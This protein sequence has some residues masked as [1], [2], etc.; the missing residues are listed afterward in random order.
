MGSCIRITHVLDIT[1]VH[2]M[3]HMSLLKIVFAQVWEHFIKKYDA[4]LSI[5]G[6]Y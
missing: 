3:T 4:S 5:G 6:V 1:A 2:I